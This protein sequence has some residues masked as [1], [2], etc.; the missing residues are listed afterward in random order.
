MNKFIG[1]GIFVFVQEFFFLI[2]TYVLA[3]VNIAFLLHV[4]SIFLYMYTVFFQNKLSWK[5][6]VQVCA[7]LTFPLFNGD[8]SFS[9]V[10]N[11]NVYDVCL[12]FSCPPLL[13]YIQF[14]LLFFYSSCL[15]S[16]EGAAKIIKF[17]VV[18][19]NFIFFVSKTYLV[20]SNLSC[21][22]NNNKLFMCRSVFV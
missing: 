16:M 17:L 22:C 19:F 21:V 9:F 14:F 11:L 13:T 1:V 20:V 6:L 8:K 4:L 2:S 10:L 5:F 7:I 3:T 15:K 12:I 18:F